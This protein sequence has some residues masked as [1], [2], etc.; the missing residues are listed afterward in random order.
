MHG[1]LICTAFCLSVHLSVTRPKLLEKIHISGTIWLRVIEFGYKSM[2][3]P[4]LVA[5]L[6]VLARCAHFNVKLLHLFQMMNQKT[7][8]R[9]LV[10]T[11]ALVCYY[12]S[13]DC[14]FVF[15]D[16]SAIKDN[17]DLRPTQSVFNLFKNDFW[18]TPMHKV[19]LILFSGL[20]LQI[21]ADYL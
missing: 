7:V 2:S 6:R 19:S 5:S 15:D 10:V 13:L 1:V 20:L 11:A 16:A 17:K 4:W 8:H 18:G 12:N 21:R 3:Q 9:L 14:D